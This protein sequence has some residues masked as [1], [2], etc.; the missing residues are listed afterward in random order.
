MPIR[1]EGK[2]GGG[3]TAAG[4]DRPRC[5]LTL[6]LSETPWNSKEPVSQKAAQW[7]VVVTY[8]GLTL[9]FIESQRL[10]ST[11][12]RALGALGSWLQKSVQDS[13]LLLLVGR[14]GSRGWPPNCLPAASAAA[15]LTGCPSRCKAVA[16]WRVLLLP[17]EGALWMVRGQK[18]T[19][20]LWGSS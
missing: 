2:A 19:I 15:E 16:R 14:G 20:H 3:L 17:L 12:V 5:P 4:V 10:Q 1:Q 13:P 7:G 18:P 8:L 11:H 9:E 6:C